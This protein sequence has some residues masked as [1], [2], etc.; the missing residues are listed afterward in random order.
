M[1]LRNLN[2][3]KLTLLHSLRGFAAVFVAICH[4]KWIFWSGGTEYV[5]LY[6]RATWEIWDYIPFAIDMVFSNGTSMVMVFYVLSGFFIAY[7]YHKNDW[8]LG[9][10]YFNR[11]LRIYIP[12]LASIGISIGAMYLAKEIYPAFA[13]NSE[14]KDFN[15]YMV[16]SYKEQSLIVLKRTLLFMRSNGWYYGSNFVVWS[17]LYEMFF[18]IIV[19]FIHKGSK[20]FLML[21]GM[22]FFITTFDLK[23][24][25]FNSFNIVHR[26]F[27]KYAFYFAIGLYLYDWMENRPLNKKFKFSYIL[28][29]SIFCF[30]LTLLGGVGKDFY[31]ISLWFGALWGCTIIII[32][33]DYDIKSNFI[34]RFFKY[35]GK[36]SY[37]LYLVHIPTYFVLSALLWK[38]T[39]KN[40]FYSRIYWLTL[41]IVILVS[42]IFYYLIEDISLK[43]ISNWKKKVLS[44]RNLTT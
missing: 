13:N 18:Y 15:G 1:S 25:L 4:A 19:P 38:F 33:L 2:A 29:F 17:L 32:F 43:I 34:I 27:L 16:G 44:K 28:A 11:A 36:I 5:K 10:F 20:T 12:Y 39:G 14:T 3:D 8:S 23:E 24:D 26:F 22:I 31:N 37:S 42:T 35:L 40:F 6:P 30:G 7:S 21:S 41:P 9:E